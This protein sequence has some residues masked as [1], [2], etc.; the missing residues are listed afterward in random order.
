VRP[1]VEARPLWFDKLTNRV[2]VEARVLH[3][4]KLTNRRSKH[5]VP[6]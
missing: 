6:V 3:F 5:R 2:C 1:P 4:D